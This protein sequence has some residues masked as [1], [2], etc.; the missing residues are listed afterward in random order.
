MHTLAPRLILYPKAVRY[1]IKL[2]VL[3][4]DAVI[5]PKY[6]LRATV[7]CLL[8]INREKHPEVT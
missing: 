2:G 6:L 4:E 7:W 3:Y 5:T 8:S 1:F